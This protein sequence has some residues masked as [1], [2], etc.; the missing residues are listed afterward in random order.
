VG[1]VSRTLFDVLPPEA[2]GYQYFDFPSKQLPAGVAENLLGLGIN[3]DD[4]AFPVGDDHGVRRG[5]QEAPELLI[6]PQYK[7]QSC[8]LFALLAFPLG[9]EDNVV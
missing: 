2:L 7:L 4:P 8:G 9:V 5:F 3:S 6:W 1:K